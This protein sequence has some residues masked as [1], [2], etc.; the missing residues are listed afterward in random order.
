MTVTLT[1]QQLEDLEEILLVAIMQ[2]DD[3]GRENCPESLKLQAI[4]KAVQA[5]V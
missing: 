2:A 1:A 3:D 4:L 5:A